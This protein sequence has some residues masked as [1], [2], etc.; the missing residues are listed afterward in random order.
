RALEIVLREIRCFQLR[1]LASQDFFAR[2]GA[3][4]MLAKTNAAAVNLI[5]KSLHLH[6]GENAAAFERIDEDLAEVAAE[7]HE[8]TSGQ[9]DT[10]R[11][12]SRAARQL[13]VQ[14]RKCDREAGVTIERLAEHRA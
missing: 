8:E 3:E 13:D 7:L 10:G 9:R 4:V 11:F 5:E 12:D 1:E 14:N 2:E 6:R